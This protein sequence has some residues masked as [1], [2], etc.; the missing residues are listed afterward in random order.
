MIIIFITILSMSFIRPFLGM[1]MPLVC[2]P[3]WFKIKSERKK[4]ILLLIAFVLGALFLLSKKTYIEGV[5]ITF[6]NDTAVA[7]GR[8]NFIVAIIKVFLGPTPIHYF[9]AKEYFVQPF[10]N[11]QGYLYTLLHLTYYI[12]FSFWI[13]YIY[14]HRRI[15]LNSLKTSLSKCFILLLAISQLLCYTIVYGSADIRQRAV[16]ITFIFIASI[17]TNSYIIKSKIPKSEFK[18]WLFILT[19]LILLTIIST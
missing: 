9:H 5:I 7:E 2:I 19:S 3:F 16:I 11:S 1:A 17:T 18:I 8:S 13:P 6:A 10:L 14:L 12:G 15:I 4:M